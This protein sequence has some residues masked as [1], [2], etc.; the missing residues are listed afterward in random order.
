MMQYTTEPDADGKRWVECD[1]CDYKL[2]T[3]LPPERVHHMCK[4]KKKRGH[5][6]GTH[7]AIMLGQMGIKS[8]GSCG[9]FEKQVQMDY[10]GSMGCRKERAKFLEHLKT[11]YKK[12]DI[13]TKA[14]ALKLAI[15][16]GLPL[17]LGGLLDEAIRRAEED[18]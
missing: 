18:E 14:T 8:E 13:P 12:A 17:T 4:G 5:G 1:T 2:H 7:L 9:C 11:A 16:E 6:P 3:T 15:R 10:L